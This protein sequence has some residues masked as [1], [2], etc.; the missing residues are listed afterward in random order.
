MADRRKT[1]RPVEVDRRSGV[2]RRQPGQTYFGR[3]NNGFS[4]LVN[5]TFA[6]IRENEKASQL[7]EQ[8]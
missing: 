1:S 3:G 6:V 2:D 7:E 5:R 8:S 4:E